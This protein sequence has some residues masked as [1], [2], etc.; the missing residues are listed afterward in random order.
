[1]IGYYE[2]VIK[3]DNVFDYKFKLA[4]LIHMCSISVEN[5]IMNFS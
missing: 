2:K 5:I 1:M 3:K 4:E